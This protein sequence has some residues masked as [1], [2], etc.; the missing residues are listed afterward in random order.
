MDVL[1][2]GKVERL[3]SM[4]RKDFFYAREFVDMDDL[5]RQFALWCMEV[6]N[7]RR[8]GTTRR[9]V[10]DDLVKERPHLIPLPPHP[11][12]EAI[13]MERKVNREGMISVDTNH[14][15]VPT[16]TTSRVVDVHIGPSTLRLFS[17]GELIATHPRLEGKHQRRL[18]PLH[19][20]SPPPE[21]LSRISATSKVKD[22]GVPLRIPTR[23]LAL[24]AAIGEGLS[25]T[26]GAQ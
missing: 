17:K 12:D 16:T 5:N 20:R 26:G 14:Y 1:S 25:Q 15:S 23:S 18:D 21:Q 11:Y 6:A 24:Y 3:I 8:H 2:K 9:I 7:T 22:G 19:R 10:A 13:R 4:I